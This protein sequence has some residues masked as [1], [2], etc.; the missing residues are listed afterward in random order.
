M[1]HY[2]V[3]GW[4]RSLL[5]LWF[6]HASPATAQE[7]GASAQTCCLSKRRAKHTH[8]LALICARGRKYIPAKEDKRRMVFKSVMTL[9]CTSAICCFFVTEFG[10]V[11]LSVWHKY[12][13][14]GL[15]KREERPKLAKEMTT[16][17]LSNWQY[18]Q[19]CNKRLSKQYPVQVQEKKKKSIIH[20]TRFQ[21]KR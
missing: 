15:N 11:A 20:K 17:T 3:K 14:N 8:S 19:N 1:T 13:E 16:T 4:F 12:N 21:K 18:W 9:V 5:A 6:L 7:S 2:H 10:R